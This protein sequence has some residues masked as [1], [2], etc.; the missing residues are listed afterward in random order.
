[1]PNPKRFDVA[2]SLIHVDDEAGRWK[3]ESFI[4]FFARYDRNVIITALEPPYRAVLDGDGQGI[5]IRLEFGD[6][7]A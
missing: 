1:M 6:S 2:G 3:R 5:K 4:S 7:G